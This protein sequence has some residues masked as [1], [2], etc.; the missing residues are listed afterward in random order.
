[1]VVLW[2]MVAALVVFDGNGGVI[3]WHVGEGR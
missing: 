1:M 3:W 2:R